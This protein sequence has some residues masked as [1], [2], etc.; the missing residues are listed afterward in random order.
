MGFALRVPL[1]VVGRVF[2]FDFDFTVRAFDFDFVDTNGKIDSSVY[3][4]SGGSGWKIATQ[5]RSK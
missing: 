5:E 2:C 3:K 1:R 4:T